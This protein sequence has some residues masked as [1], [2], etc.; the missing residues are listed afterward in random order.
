MEQW[1]SHWRGKGGWGGKGGQEKLGKKRKIREE[2]AKIGKVLS[3]C[4]S[5]TDRAGYATVME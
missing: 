2:K 5:D 3:L 1:R 4:P